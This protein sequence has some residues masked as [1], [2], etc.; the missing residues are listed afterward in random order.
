MA[1]YRQVH[2][3]F[4][5]DPY[6]EELSVKEKFFYLYLLTNSKTK[7]CG[8]YEISMKLMR[9]ETG[10]TQQEI[11]QFIDKFINDR[12]ID[13]DPENSEFLLLNWLK[14]NSFRSPKVVVCIEKELNS[15][16][17]KRFLR[18]VRGII[19]SGMGIDRLLIDYIETMDRGSQEE[20]EEEEEEEYNNKD[21]IQYWNTFEI[22]NHS[23]KNES[24]LKE[25][26]KLSSMEIDILKVSIERYATAYKDEKHYYNHKW[27]LDKFIKQ[28][29]GYKDWTD[30]GQRWIE[31]KNPLKAAPV[32]R[33]YDHGFEQQY[34]KMSEEELEQMS[35]KN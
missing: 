6:V 20:E 5:Q 14:H 8:C 30:E 23:L 35:R 24:I 16:K 18:Y 2:I 15:I 1:T 25:L 31:Y 33:K 7:Q 32:K 21:I 4:W 17:T 9:Y 27:T 26:K 34:A 12:K 28:G 11:S 29:N 3:T 10:L 22:V 13:Y 19:D